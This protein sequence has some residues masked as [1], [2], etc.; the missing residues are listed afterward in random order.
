MKSVAAEWECGSENPRGPGLRQPSA[1]FAP[2]SECESGRGLPQSKTLARGPG[3]PVPS[4]GYRI[5]GTALAPVEPPQAGRPR[6]I[7]SPFEFR[8]AKSPVDRREPRF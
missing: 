7:E 6:V 1:A 2:E 5:S 8:R 3:R 4:G